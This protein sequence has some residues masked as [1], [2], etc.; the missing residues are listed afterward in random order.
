MRRDA[1]MSAAQYAQR[2]PQTVLNAMRRRRAGAQQAGA[3]ARAAATWIVATQP[4]CAHAR[5]GEH[6]PVAPAWQAPL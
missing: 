2:K 4:L 3:Q 1:Y 6:K 5:D